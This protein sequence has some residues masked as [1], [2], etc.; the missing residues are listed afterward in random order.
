MKFLIAL[1]L[2]VSA[3]AFAENMGREEWVK[4]YDTAQGSDMQVVYKLKSYH[5]RKSVVYPF[6][7]PL[8][9]DEESNCLVYPLQAEGA[10]PHVNFCPGEGQRVNGLVPVEATYGQEED[11]VYC[12]KKISRWFHEDPSFL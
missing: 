4:C 12:E 11:T 9:L 8:I 5:G 10:V 3:S 2:L 7:Q 1:S 6:N